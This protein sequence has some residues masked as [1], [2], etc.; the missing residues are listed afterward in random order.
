MFFAYSKINFNTL[1]TADK[2]AFQTRRKS[3]KVKPHQRLH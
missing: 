1:K 3:E 2:L